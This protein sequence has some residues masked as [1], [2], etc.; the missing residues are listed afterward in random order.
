MG[1]KHCHEPSLAYLMGRLTTNRGINQDAVFF[2]A[3][4]PANG[5]FTI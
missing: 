3:R 2:K 4:I 1:E 5:I